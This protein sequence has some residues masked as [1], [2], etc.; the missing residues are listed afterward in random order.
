LDVIELNAA[1]KRGSALVI[2]GEVWRGKDIK[3][4]VI[5]FAASLFSSTQHPFSI[6]F[7]SLPQSARLPSSIPFPNQSI[8]LLTAIMWSHLLFAAG[9][10]APAL[11]QA[12]ISLGSAATFGVL[13]A[14][15]VTNTGLT[16]I[17]G[18]VGVS[19]GTAITGFPPGI[20]SGTIYSAG[21]I[22]AAAQ[23]DALLAYNAASALTPTQDLTGQDLGGLTLGPGVYSFSSSAQLTGTL[24]LDAGG[25]ANAQFV[26]QIVS[27]IT[28]ASASVV[29]LINGAQ[30]CNVI[31]RIGSSA[32]L[33]TGT[34]F[35]GVILANT[36]ITVTTGVTN[37]G[38][39]VALNAAVTL[40]TNTIINC[41]PNGVTS[42]ST[43]APVSTAIVTSSTINPSSTS[44][45]V[46]TSS[47]TVV[48][49]S[50][51]TT[52]PPSSSTVNPTST[53][54][55]TPTGTSICIP[56]AQ[57]FVGGIPPPRCG[58][59]DVFSDWITNA[60]KVYISPNTTECPSYRRE[61]V[62]KAC[63]DT[64]DFQ[65]KTCRDVYAESRR[66]LENDSF[67]SAS[68]KCKDQ[69]DECRELNKDH[70]NKNECP[71]FGVKFRRA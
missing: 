32:T 40:D 49:S 14:T 44:I 43:S 62:D 33:G 50:G 51:I 18:D 22:A 61:N 56:P 24:T 12:Q 63:K 26:F 54:S 68:K 19:P 17:T 1:L 48:T 27:T 9:V 15:T 4:E 70:A 8:Q 53:T 16:V 66:G 2:R 47:T 46:V 31:F 28:T 30:A 39:L 71:S 38:S 60:L 59:N 58:C 64:C 34:T 3:E 37:T 36:A 55:G 11:V 52:T 65:W 69:R 20:A 23:A 7:L 57:P 29:N 5:P 35:K 45:I 67:Q 25:N 6:I 42:S 21:P 13:G 10:F 41:A